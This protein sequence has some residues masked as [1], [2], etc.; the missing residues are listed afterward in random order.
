MIIVAIDETNK[1]KAMN[2]IDCLDPKKCWIKL[3]SVSFNAL[4]QEIIFYGANK[5][6]NIFLDLK[7]HDIPNTVK[8]SIMGLS[9]LPIKMLTIHISGGK[10]N[11][12]LCNGGSY[13][14]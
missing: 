4:G 5:G 1:I 10:K 8:K 9:S 2:I 14:S 12:D 3:G 7:L 11:D 13:K 6:F